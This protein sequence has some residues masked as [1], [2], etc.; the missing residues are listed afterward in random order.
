MLV[1][2][3]QACTNL[4][5]NGREQNVMAISGVLNYSVLFFWHDVSSHQVKYVQSL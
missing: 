5:Y 2:T 1:F 4:Q 3:L